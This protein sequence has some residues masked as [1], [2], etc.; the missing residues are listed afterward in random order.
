MVSSIFNILVFSS[1]YETL[2]IPTNDPNR[3]PH[4]PNQVPND[5][6]QIPNDAIQI[7]EPK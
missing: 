6:N 2:H 1:L 5:P 4:D 3:I 7:P